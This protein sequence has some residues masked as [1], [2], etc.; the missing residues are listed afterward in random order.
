MDGVKRADKL[1]DVTFMV[2]FDTFP[3][4]NQNP[5]RA[6]KID[7]PKYNLFQFRFP[8]QSFTSISTNGMSEIYARVWN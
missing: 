6:P 2:S 5:F 7:H 3:I 1:H 8:L 4:P